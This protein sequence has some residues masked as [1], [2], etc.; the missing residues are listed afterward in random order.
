[1]IITNIYYYFTAVSLLVALSVYTGD[2]K[3]GIDGSEGIVNW[4]Y[5]YALGWVA[6]CLTLIAGPVAILAN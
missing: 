1:M 3:S 5:S 6:F 4:G 2:Y